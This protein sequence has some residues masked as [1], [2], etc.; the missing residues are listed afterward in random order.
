MF[1]FL[2]RL[3]KRDIKYSLVRFRGACRWISLPSDR[4]RL[5]VCVLSYANKHESGINLT[6]T[7]GKYMYFPKSQNIPL[8]IFIP[9]LACHLSI[10]T[11]FLLLI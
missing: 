8:S 6:L 11:T 2:Y 1:W 9:I 10:S 3:G 7:S 5:T 4:A